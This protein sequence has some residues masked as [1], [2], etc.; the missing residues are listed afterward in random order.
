MCRNGRRKA[1][2]CHAKEAP[3]LY[4]RHLQ[5]PDCAE[6]SRHDTPFPPVAAR[7]R[8]E[9]PPKKSIWACS[10][11]HQPARSVPI[12]HLIEY[13]WFA[14]VAPRRTTIIQEPRSGRGA[15]SFPLQALLS[16]PL[17]HPSCP[18]EKKRARK[19]KSRSSLMPARSEGW[20]VSRSPL[21]RPDFLHARCRVRSQ[22]AAPSDF[23]R[24]SSIVR[25]CPKQGEFFA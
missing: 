19:V 21:A 4:A 18:R 22:S 13:F 24:D 9:A 7:K 12:L 11:C 17:C 15:T 20:P 8:E 16:Q 23:H 25:W 2:G 14:H 3:A 6:V 1:L 10:W 5:V